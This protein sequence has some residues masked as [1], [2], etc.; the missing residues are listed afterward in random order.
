MKQ[1]EIA[2]LLCIYDE[3]IHTTEQLNQYATEAMV[4]IDHL[5]DNLSD[6]QNIEQIRTLIFD[7][8]KYTTN[9]PFFFQ[10]LYLLLFQKKSGPKIDQF[11][12]LYGIAEFIILL[13]KAVNNPLRFPQ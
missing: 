5:I 12:E 2:A 7:S 6:C 13:R 10:T 11:I 9:V 3:D 8:A 4:A 1:N